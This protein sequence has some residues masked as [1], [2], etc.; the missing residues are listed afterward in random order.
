MRSRFPVLVASVAL[1]LA[2]GGCGGEER[3]SQAAFVRQ[4]D[5]ICKDYQGRQA[6]LGTPKSI[7]D[8]ARLSEATKPLVVEQLA[9]LRDLKAPK[10]VQ[11]DFDQALDL[12][13]HQVP[14][15]DQLGK[16]ATGG[17]QDRV[18][19]IAADANALD[20]KANALAKSSGLKVCGQG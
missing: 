5:A 19:K 6:R 15:I 16:A 18:V 13:D 4:A 12:L 17:D 3:L 8:V 14:V 1:A 9:K 20:G 7:K 11:G 10:D 2:V